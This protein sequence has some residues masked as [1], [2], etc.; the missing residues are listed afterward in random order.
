MRLVIERLQPPFVS[1]SIANQQACNRR[2]VATLRQ[3]VPLFQVPAVFRPPAPARLPGSI[4]G[5]NRKTI[6]AITKL[7][8]L[9]FAP[10]HTNRHSRTHATKSH[11]RH[12]R[13]ALSFQ[14]FICEWLH[15]ETSRAMRVFKNG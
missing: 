10:D 14:S 9:F 4:R 6:L 8:R 3:H 13:F 7:I 1:S 15:A 5:R 12:V 11:A 2:P